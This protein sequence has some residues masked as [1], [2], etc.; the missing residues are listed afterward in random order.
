MAVNRPFAGTQAYIKYGWESTFG[1]PVAC[2]KAYSQGVRLSTYDIDNDP[3]YVYGLGSQ[4]LSRSIAKTFKGTW[5]VEFIHSDIWYL[6]GVLGGS[7]D[8]TGTS[9]YRYAYTN[10][11]G[12]SNSQTS[13]T[14]EIGADMGD[15]DSLQTLAGCIT[16]NMSL[17]CAVGEPTRVRLDGWYKTLAKTTSL[18]TAATVLEEPTV[19]SM[20]SI[21]FPTGTTINDVQSVELSFTR[22]NDP[23]YALGSR[24]PQQNVP[25]NREWNIRVSSTYELD[26]DFWDH[27]LGATG[28]PDA[29]PAEL[30]TCAVTI[31]TGAT[32]AVRSMT[33]NF[34]NVF[35]S[36]GSLP[37]SPEDLVKTD[38]E[39]RARSLSSVICYNN[40]SAEP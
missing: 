28:A 11:S 12:I 20:A 17:T 40:T 22:N 3:E 24:F 4:D 32:T 30:A 5:G 1:T 6:K 33:F 2:N 10:A 7:P 16:N 36:R 14:I 9:P 15:T 21:Q 25:K 39:L 37:M 29:D 27:L 34:A 13:S 8:K 18:N 35:V 38:I 31:S 23:V 26:T 19:F